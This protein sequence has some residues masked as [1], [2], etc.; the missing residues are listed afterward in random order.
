MTH[1]GGS[2][3]LLLSVHTYEIGPPRSTTAIVTRRRKKVKN[4]NP[5]TNTSSL[6]ALFERFKNWNPYHMKL[7]TRREGLDFSTKTD[8]LP[9]KPRN[10]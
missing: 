6:T 5:S 1:L 3:S 9:R 8:F 4:K 10:C 7:R 2:T